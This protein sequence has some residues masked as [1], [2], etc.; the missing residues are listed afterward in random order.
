MFTSRFVRLGSV[1]AALLM[2]FSLLA[3][4]TA[5]ARMGGS[6]GSRGMRTFQSAPTTTLSPSVV[7]PVQRSMTPNTGGYTAPN[8]FG[9]PSTFGQQRG[10]FLSGL[11][12][13]I[14]G[15]MLGGLLFHGLFGSMMGYG[16][17]G[18]GGGFSMIFQLLLIGGLIWFAVRFFRRQSAATAAGGNGFPMSGQ[19][20]GNSAPSFGGGF[21]RSMPANRDEIGV[22]NADLASFEKI[23]ADVQDAF[24]REDHQGLRRLTTPEMVSYLS[25]ELADNATRGVRNEV[26]N[27]TFLDGDVAESWREGTREYATVAMKWSA[28]DIMRDRQ[29]NAVVKGDATQPVTTT[30][31]WTFVRDNGGNWLL[32]AIQDASGK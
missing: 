1:V 11:G 29:T 15:G 26:S 17:G 23:L 18:I 12:G 13:G 31:L 3:V 16:F 24:T 10:G 19:G 21:G 4:S 9:Q 5:E 32:S 28:V 7:A 14:V 30:E 27:L 8:T 2:V 25:E 20:F 6:F 22:N